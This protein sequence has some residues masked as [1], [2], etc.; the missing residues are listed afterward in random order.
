M[1]AATVS[2]KIN[3]FE[4]QR[5]LGA[6]AQGTVY[7]ARDTRLNRQ[8]AIKTPVVGDKAQEHRRR[9]DTLLA[10]ARMVSQLSHPNVVPLFDAGEENALP[11]L[12]FEYVEGTVLARIIKRERRLSPA[13]AVTIAVELLAALGYAHSKGVMHRDI[14]PGNIMLRP[15]CGRRRAL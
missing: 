7:L 6:G 14:K 12:V 10:E 4:I 15:L 3:R 9:V 1:L 11:F 13:R 5:T 2:R 8:V